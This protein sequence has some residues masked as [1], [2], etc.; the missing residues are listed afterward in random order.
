MWAKASAL[1]LL[2]IAIASFPDR[3]LDAQSALDQARKNQSQS[4]GATRNTNTTERSSSKAGSGFDTRSTAPNP[5]SGQ[6]AAKPNPVGQPIRSTANNPGY[7][8]AA[9]SMRTTA[10][11]A[12]SNPN[13]RYDASGRNLNPTGDARVAKGIDNYRQPRTNA[14]APV[15][16]TAPTVSAPSKPTVATSRPASPSFTL[17]SSPSRSSSTSSSSSSSSS[18]KKR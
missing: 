16:R 12:P 14:P 17:S 6:T 11:P 9:P 13:S 4:S 3:E 18:A 2:A 15:T 10:P 5:V 1:G 8:P 7:K